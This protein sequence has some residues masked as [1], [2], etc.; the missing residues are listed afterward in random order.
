MAFSAPGFFVEIFGAAE[1]HSYSVAVKEL[2]NKKCF[3][4]GGR[5]YT[6][7]RGWTV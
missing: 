3:I 7:D 1:L 2:I 6:D 4:F 5:I